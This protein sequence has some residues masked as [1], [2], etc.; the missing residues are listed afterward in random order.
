M[1]GIWIFN[2]GFF[3]E[4]SDAFV[5]EFHRT[6]P[7]TKC[8]HIHM[9]LTSLH[10]VLFRCRSARIG[11]WSSTTRLLLFLILRLERDAK[12]H[13]RLTACSWFVCADFWERHFNGTQG[14][15]FSTSIWVDRVVYPRFVARSGSCKGQCPIQVLPTPTPSLQ[16]NFHASLCFFFEK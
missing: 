1:C 13:N 8:T 6:I 7:F 4:G 10:R 11:G 15:V 12:T 9:S 16:A 2:R 5:R 3:S 14:P